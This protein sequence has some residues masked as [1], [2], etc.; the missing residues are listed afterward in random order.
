[1][2]LFATLG[3]LKGMIIDLEEKEKIIIGRDPDLCD[4][5]LEDTSV[6]RKHLEVEKTPLG[7][8]ATNLSLTN[9]LEINENVI[10]T[11]ELNEGD[12]LKIGDTIFE[13][14]KDEAAIFEEEKLSDEEKLKDN[15]EPEDEKPEDEELED[16]ELEDEEP[17]EA[18]QKEEEI[19]PKEENETIFQ[20]EESFFPSSF[21]SD[22]P[23]ILKVISGANASAEFGLEKEKQYIIGK[24]PN[25]CDIVFT[26]LSVSKQNTKISVDE[27]GDIFIEDLNSK[28]GSFVN[29][30][31]I[32]EK[33]KISNNDLITVGTST[34]LI[35]SKES[36]DETIYTPA[37]A[38]E[39][40]EEKKEKT[41]EK[42]LSIWQKQKIPTK[43]LIF[44]SSIFIIIFVIFLSFF[45]LFKSSKIDEKIKNPNE[46]IATAIK[47]FSTIEFSFAP[48]SKELLLSGHVMSTLDKQ[49]LMYNL[50]Q[51]DFISKIEDNV[52]IDEGVVKNFNQVLDQADDYRSVHLLNPKPSEFILSGYVDNTKQFEALVDYVNLNFNYLD[53]LKNMVVINEVLN[54]EIFTML[55][56]YNL[57]GITF[58]MISNELVLSGRYNEK[59]KDEF[60][61]LISELKKTNGITYIKNLALPSSQEMARIDI[62]NKY[63][64]TGYAT[65]DGMDISVVANGKIVTIGDL[66]DGLLITQIEPSE[67]YLEKDEIKYKI[68]YSR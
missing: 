61:K 63:K 49:E 46:M 31:P 4:I 20:Q 55:Q 1:M 19:G 35:I 48:S 6:S 50:D 40:K 37:P 18:I 60:Y 41:K 9:P 17:E 29:N 30:T 25:F 32:K 59:E 42:E 21:I 5:V 39:V 66:L 24:D 15:E 56:K 33:T 44:A 10:D 14:T 65:A 2:K 11:Q 28:N 54:A 13:Y 36:M 3:P 7:F 27:N 67:I 57:S 47:D 22:T 38:F 62:T 43:H 45:S 12:F 16:E 34:F 52:I 53:K 8:K 51:L 64:I 58:E 23:Y 26:D 68:G